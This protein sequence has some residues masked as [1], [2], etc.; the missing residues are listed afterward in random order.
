M[1]RIDLA[2]DNQL[3]TMLKQIEDDLREIKNR[4]QHSGLSGL[5]GY[6]VSSPDTWDITGSA[7]DGGGDYGYREF[8][9]TFTASGKQPFPIENVQLD[10]RFGGTGESNKPTEQPDG[11]WG[12]N[13][14]V[15][16]A[17]MWDRNPEIESEYYGSPDT[18]RWLFG[19]FVTGTVNY[20]IKAY[21]A[22]TSDGTIE[23]EDI[24]FDF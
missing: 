17:E 23:V 18:Y 4:Q 24:T 9:I 20:Y 15:N 16:Y 14:G 1:N 11:T 7:S 19:F 2:P 13:D 8:W 3:A 5:L 6:F 10:I 21:A 22:G 12:W